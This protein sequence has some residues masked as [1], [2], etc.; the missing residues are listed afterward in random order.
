MVLNQ[1]LDKGSSVQF[2]SKMMLSNQ[3]GS[4]RNLSRHFQN[5]IYSIRKNNLLMQDEIS[6]SLDPFAAS[7]G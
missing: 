6:Y 1:H 5:E 3:D 7:V 4:N 2:M